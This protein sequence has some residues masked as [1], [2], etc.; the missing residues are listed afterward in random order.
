MGELPEKWPASKKQRKN[1]KTIG[2]K[3]HAMQ[4]RKSFVKSY[5]SR[6]HLDKQKQLTMTS[7]III[8]SWKNTGM[9]P[10]TSLRYGRLKPQEPQNLLPG[11]R[12]GKIQLES[13]DFGGPRIRGSWP[14]KITGCQKKQDKQ[15][16]C[17]PFW[18]NSF[19][20]KWPAICRGRF[21]L[22]FDRSCTAALVQTL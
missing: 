14:Q 8:P 15:H 20:R 16:A 5:Q 7:P 12:M 19:S 13:Q 17:L 18:G 22:E 21:L 10:Q 3:L 1:R 6:K 9:T 11:C 2:E 4:G